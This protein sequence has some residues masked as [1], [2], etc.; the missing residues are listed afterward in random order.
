MISAEL[1]FF[2][3]AI[4]CNMLGFA[5]LFIYILFFLFIRCLLGYFLDRAL[6]NEEILNSFKKK[7]LRK[8][9]VI[10]FDWQLLFPVC[11]G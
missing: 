5:K 6:S 3:K 7:T 1:E 4:F 2:Y 8:M 11:F 10:F 9:L